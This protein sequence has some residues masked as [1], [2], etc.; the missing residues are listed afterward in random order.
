MKFYVVNYKETTI[1][2]DNVMNVESGVCDVGYSNEEEAINVICR[3]C[4]DRMNEF[5]DDLGEESDDIRNGDLNEDDSKCHHE[6]NDNGDWQMVRHFG[7]T[8]EYWVTIVNV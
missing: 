1:D 8:Y 2:A 4:D 7:D 5:V 3:L 6:S